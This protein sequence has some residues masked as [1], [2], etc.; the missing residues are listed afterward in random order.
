MHDSWLLAQGF[1][2][3]EQLKAMDDMNDFGSP[4]H[5]LR[6]YEHPRSVVHMNDSRS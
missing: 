4:T 3:Y 2:S 1:S 5:G 6:C